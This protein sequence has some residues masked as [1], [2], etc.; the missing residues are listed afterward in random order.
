M[1]YEAISQKYN[2]DL[3]FS[4]KHIIERNGYDT[5]SLDLD[6]GIFTSTNKSNLSLLL[7]SN[8]KVH[9]EIVRILQKYKSYDSV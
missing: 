8:G 2:K 7:S 3:G 9:D 5:D 4:V 1:V 6:V